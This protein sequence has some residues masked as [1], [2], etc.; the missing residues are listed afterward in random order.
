[1]LRPT[2]HSHPDRT[3]I[4]VASLLLRYLRKNHVGQYDDLRNHV[5]KLL[6]HVQ[7]ADTIFLPAINLLY[8]LGLVEYRPKTDSFEFTGKTKELSAQ[9]K[10]SRPKYKKNNTL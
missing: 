2:K 7:N 1:M 10:K 3:V 6:S 5:R 4:S 8:M 9:T